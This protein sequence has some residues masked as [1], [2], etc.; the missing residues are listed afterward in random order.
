MIYA[1]DLIDWIPRIFVSGSLIKRELFEIP[2]R[3]ADK[4]FVAYPTLPRDQTEAG[5]KAL[6]G[7]FKKYSLSRKHVAAQISAYCAA[8]IL[9]EG[10]KRAGKRLSREKLVVSLEKLYEFDTGLTPRITY[11]PN[12]RIGALGSYVV[13]VDIKKKK[14]VPVSEWITL[15]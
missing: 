3:F 1:A 10:I 7:L 5:S 8:R 11:D 14:F 13:T 6:A 2:E 9:V 12:R 15:E 4:I